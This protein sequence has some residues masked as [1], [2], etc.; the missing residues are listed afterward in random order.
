MRATALRAHSAFSAG[1][2]WTVIKSLPAIT[3]SLAASPAACATPSE[4]RCFHRGSSSGIMSSVTY[5]DASSPWSDESS[6]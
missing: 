2:D 4:R 1:D 6:R 5:F 3:S